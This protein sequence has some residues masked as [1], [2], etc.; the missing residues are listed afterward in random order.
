ML[1]EYSRLSTGKHSRHYGSF[2]CVYPVI[3][4]RSRGLSIGVNLSLDNRCNY[5]CVYC[6]VDRSVPCDNDRADPEV[7]GQELYQHLSDIASEPGGPEVKD[8]TFAGNGEPMAFRELD[9]C[10]DIARETL[11]LWGYTCPVVVITNGSFLHRAHARRALERLAA[12]SGQL[13]VKLDAGDQE[14]MA[15]L[16]GTSL[17]M[18]RLEQN[19]FDASRILSVTLQ[20]MFM[21]CWGKP[22]SPAAVDSYIACLNR[23]GT[24]GA[25]IDGVQVYTVAR[26]P[27]CI[28]ITSLSTSELQKIASRIETETGL[29][30]QIFPSPVNS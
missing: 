14:R 11:S 12:A 19:I 1:K 20:S 8:V 9:R 16:N 28:N 2:S 10:I 18:D 6:E 15:R 26:Q 3:S 24:A 17:S 25:R 29:M 5:N 30:T 22:P 27:R 23:L 13:W 21:N 7:F 4:R